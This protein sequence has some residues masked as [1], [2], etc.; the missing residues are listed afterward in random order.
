MHTE[1]AQIISLTSYGNEFLRTGQVSE[2]YFPGGTVFQ[3]CNRIDFRDF[4]KSL[5]SSKQSETISA[6]NPIDWFQLLK[7]EG[8]ARLRLY[9]KPSEDKTFGPE[10]N[11]A[12]FVGGGGTWLIETNFGNYSHYWQKRWQVTNQDAPDGKIWVVNYARTVER[13]KPAN[14]QPDPQKI[15]TLFVDTLKEL[16]DFCVQQKLSSWLETFEKADKILSDPTPNKLYYHYD[17]IV[18]RNY[19]LYA[20]QL[21]FSAGTAWVFGGMGWWNDMGFKDKDV[22]EKYLQLSQ[23]LYEQLIQSILATTNSF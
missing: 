15:R 12:G 13:F 5:F 11:L 20:Q 10:Y 16:I 14:Q 17:L 1:L 22:Q 21:L 9:Y 7:K 6:N 2:N 8:C 3:H 18:V 19:P 23:R 4:K